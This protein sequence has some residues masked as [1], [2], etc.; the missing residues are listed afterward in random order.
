MN[1]NL[2]KS[3]HPI[4][5]AQMAATGLLLL[6]ALFLLP[7]LLFGTGGAGPEPDSPAGSLPLDRTVVTPAPSADSQVSVR[8]ALGEG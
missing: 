8:V 7:L 6:L 4:G 2:Q 5:A 1:H 3:N